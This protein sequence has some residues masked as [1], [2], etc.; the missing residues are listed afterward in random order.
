SPGA[1][2]SLK[3]TSA[4]PVSSDVSV[5]AV[6]SREIPSRK[7]KSRIKKMSYLNMR[8]KSIFFLDE[9]LSGT[10]FSTERHLAAPNSGNSINPAFQLF[11]L[12]ILRKERPGSTD[13]PNSRTLL[14]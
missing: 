11:Q 14:K 6:A 13:I 10:S 3:L 9:R 7:T 4:I 8:L 5:Q 2:I 1:S 12:R